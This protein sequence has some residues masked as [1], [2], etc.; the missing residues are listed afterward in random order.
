MPSGPTTHD[1]A[2]PDGTTVHI[3]PMT[4]ADAPLLLAMWDRTSPRSRQ[5][6]FHGAYDLDERNVGLFTDY[7][8]RWQ[9]A[10]A[11]TT[12]RD[13]DER[14]VGVSRYVIDQDQPTHAEFAALVEDAHQ[15]RGIG[16]AL[17]RHVAE[18]AHEAGVR[19]LSGDVL[20]DNESM[21]RLIRDLGLRHT[22]RRA[23]EVVRSD[24]DLDLGEDFLRVVDDQE[25][26]AARAAV[27]RFLRPSSV[28]V[29]GASRDPDS[30]SG[31]LLANLVAGEF[32]GPVFPVNPH[33]SEVAGLASHARL[34]DLPQVPELV[35]VTLPAPLVNDVVD[36]AAALGVHAVC[37]ISAGFA[38]DGEEG[39]QRQADL[40]RRARGHGL[41]IVGPNCMGVMN[42]DPAVSLNATLTPR[43]P[44]HG[45]TAVLS[46][47]GVLG[48]TILDAAA[49]RG[50]G[51][52]SFVSV[53]NKADISGND[54]LR[55]WETDPDT[56]QV[57]L[58]LESFGNP[59]TFSRIARRIGRH[60]TIVAVKAA[61]SAAGA[62]VA[63]RGTRTDPGA[64]QAVDA[65]FAQTGVIRT[66]TLPELLDVAQLLATQPLPSG[67]AVGVVTNSGGPGILAADALEA[68]GLVVAT[69]SADT[70]ARL[71]PH[72]GEAAADDPVDVRPGGTVEDF[73]AAVRI[74]GDSPEVD[75]VLAIMVPLPNQH[76][77]EVA[78][79]L[80]RA[81]DELDEDTP[82]VVVM[83]TPD[84]QVPHGL[85]AAGIPC[86]PFPESAAAALG[87]VALHAAWRR[88]PLG[89]VVVPDDVDRTRARRLVERAIATT[90]G[91]ATAHPSA[92]SAWLDPVDAHAVLDAYAIPRPE[93]RFV[94]T[95]DG[96]ADAFDQ[97]DGPVVVKIVDGKPPDTMLD[98]VEAGRRS[99]RA[100]A[101]GARDLITRRE[102]GLADDVPDRFTHPI[103]PVQSSDHP[104]VLTGH[105][106]GCR[107]LVQEMEDGTELS[108]SVHHDPVF[109][110]IVVTGLGGDLADLV[111]D[112]AARITP[113]TDR[114]VEEMLSD[115]RIRPVLDGWRG[116]PAADL[117]ALV[118]LLVRVNALV[119]DLPE[120][121][122][123]A[124]N[125]VF[126]GPGGVSVADVRI[127][128][129][130]VPRHAP[131]ATP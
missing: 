84:G 39:W 16:S 101:A 90:P 99:R 56:D 103:A 13:H 10:L 42:V 127:R 117:D 124:M 104:D 107:L 72:V 26:T 2:L 109:G 3:R 28:A 85:P 66:D 61:R 118:D 75:A 131:A 15:G 74:V 50:I 78:R 14:L 95:P 67:P 96:A 12:G 55:W 22:D 34:A 59:R 60:K 122:E 9:L 119:E 87:R 43:V 37:I 94:T 129:A 45:R 7:D 46:Q 63:A 40:L 33:T 128:V 115:L 1:H 21:L 113:L 105:G 126:V 112:R 51:V 108:V 121:V 47:S 64:D 65:L 130:P 102:A 53:G 120:V 6:R 71:A 24:L 23:S 91:M 57:L 81:R 80:V 8:P 58:Y 5:L 31:M 83:M 20:A 52:S 100:A 62:R 89:R 68:N 98:T 38:D 36:E 97:L 25:R 76:P 106:P 110:P 54:L 114:D 111:D 116:T 88:R 19:V 48:T 44:P 125:P 11:A 27:H 41:R 30:L 70:R 123:V 82:M 49:A 79:A 35:V 73:G 92:R 17:V 29:V 4:P 77:D 93:A 18:A 69:L 32:A 86:H